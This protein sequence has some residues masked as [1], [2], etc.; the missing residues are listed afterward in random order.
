VRHCSVRRD[1]SRSARCVLIRGLW[2]GVA[3]HNGRA[4]RI[5]DRNAA[6]QPRVTRSGDLR[7]RGRRDARTRRGRNWRTS[8]RVGLGISKREK[9]VCI[10]GRFHF[11]WRAR[12]AP[13]QPSRE[14]APADAAMG[15]QDTALQI[16]WI[17]LTLPVSSCRRPLTKSVYDIEIGFSSVTCVRVRSAPMGPETIE[18]LASTFRDKMGRTSPPDIQ[19]CINR[20][21]S[22]A[23][24]RLAFGSKSSM[25]VHVREVKID[26][27]TT[28]RPD[29]RLIRG[30]CQ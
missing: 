23:K 20:R 1:A 15:T 11:S 27:R 17:S 24:K 29:R 7:N 26:R 22:R 5:L 3:F 4:R 18:L 6:R 28:L 14:F 12:F 8:W 30:S 25:C 16:A 13:E 21:R 19:I 10:S 2:F 9:N